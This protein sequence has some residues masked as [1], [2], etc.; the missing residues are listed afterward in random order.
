MQ[1]G[2]NSVVYAINQNGVDNLWAQPLDGSPGHPLTHFTSELI[3][4]FHWSPDGKTLALVREHD[5]ADVVLLREES[6]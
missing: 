1:P 5:V 3:T 2:S 4:D 6:Q